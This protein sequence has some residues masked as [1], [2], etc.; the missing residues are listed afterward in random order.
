MRPISGF[1]WRE[2]QKNFKS[3]RQAY[4]MPSDNLQTILG[5]F[6]SIHILLARQTYIAT[7]RKQALAIVNQT[8]LESEMHFV[9]YIFSQNLKIQRYQKFIF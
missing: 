3:Y 6:F 4:Y 7:I 1:T 8:S 5:I 9:I 2:D